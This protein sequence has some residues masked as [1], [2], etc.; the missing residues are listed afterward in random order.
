MKIKAI[1]L[2]ITMCALFLITG[3]GGNAMTTRTTVSSAPTSAAHESLKGKRILIAYYS[4]S[5]HTRQVAEQI[6]KEVGGDIFEIKTVKAYPSEHNAA[7]EVAKKELD[8]QARPELKDTISNM[9]DYDVIILGYPIWWYT[10]PMA[11]NTFLESYDMTGKIIVPFCTSGGHGVE[12]SV[13]DIRKAAGNAEV[14]DGLL[15]NDSSAID[16]WLKQSGL[17]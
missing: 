4:W 15:A 8:A 1:L 2:A 13:G 17:L 11:V 14:L 9:A 3:C 16:P 5:G 12:K 6:Q 7:S 10:A